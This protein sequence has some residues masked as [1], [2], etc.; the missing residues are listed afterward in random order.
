MWDLLL[1]ALSGGA[2]GV[3]VTRAPFYVCRVR[4]PTESKDIVSLVSGDVVSEFGLVGEAIVGECVPMLKDGER[5]TEANFRP[6]PY[7][8]KLLHDVIARHAPG[9]PGLQAEARR[10]R[11]GWVYVIDARTPTPNGRVPSHDIVGS[12]EVRDGEVVENSYQPNPDHRLFTSAGLFVLAT[13]LHE[14]LMEQINELIVAS[15]NR[16]G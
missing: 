8:V 15:Q 10:Q 16:T 11:N 13:A 1:R 9:L 4:T 12:F 6:N 3:P 7:F 14:R 2:R 5:V